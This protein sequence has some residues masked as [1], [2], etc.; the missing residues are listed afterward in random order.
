MAITYENVIYDR[1]IDSM[2]T[3]LADEFNISVVFDETADRGNQS[4][5]VTP[6]EDNQVDTLASGQLRQVTVVIN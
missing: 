1:V 6:G 2:N 5:L 3:I 4:F